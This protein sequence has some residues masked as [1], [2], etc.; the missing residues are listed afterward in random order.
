MN[1]WLPSP[2]LD[3][4]YFVSEGLFYKVCL[5]CERFGE[6]GWVD[7]FS[8]DEGTT[9]TGRDVLSSLG[10]LISRD[11][12]LM[13]C[14]CIFLLYDRVEL[15]FPNPLHNYLSLFRWFFFYF[16]DKI[17]LQ[18]ETTLFVF[19]FYCNLRCNVNTS[20][21]NEIVRNRRNNPTTTALR[22]SP[23]TTEWRSFD[24]SATAANCSALEHCQRSANGAATCLSQ[25]FPCSLPTQKNSGGVSWS[26]KLT[27]QTMAS[28][29]N[30]KLG[31]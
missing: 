3:H 11:V 21:P 24:I 15:E 1:W 14:C 27:F 28:L 8:F 26:L 16:I 25:L 20:K 13:W 9:V 7:L 31:Q 17:Y 2:S 5:G 12:S 10:E 23:A 30:G 19:Y 18:Y 22:R 29:R 4:F 6:W